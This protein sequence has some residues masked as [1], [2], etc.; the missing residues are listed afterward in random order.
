MVIKINPTISGGFVF[1]I[2]RDSKVEPLIRGM[3]E[4]EAHELVKE[5]LI[6]GTRDLNV[7]VNELISRVKASQ[8]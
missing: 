2:M 1:K 6:A 8:E 5:I 7:N 4:S 3:D